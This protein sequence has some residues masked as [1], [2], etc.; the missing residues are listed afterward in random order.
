MSD[1]SSSNHAEHVI[2][3][4]SFEVLRISI[5]ADK[6]PLPLVLLD[7]YGQRRTSILS[8]TFTPSIFDNSFNNESN[9]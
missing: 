8:R 2:I 5:L 3:N 9:E 1:M 6:A 4:S 7:A